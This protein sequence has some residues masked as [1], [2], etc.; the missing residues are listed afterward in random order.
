MVHRFD[1]V[2]LHKW[3]RPASDPPANLGRV[4]ALLAQAKVYEDD[5]TAVFES[6]PA[7]PAEGARRAL[8]RRLAAPGRLARPLFLLGRP[9][10]RL[11]VYNPDPSRPLTIAIEAA[12]FRSPRTV[13]LRSGDVGL[14]RWRAEPGEA[15]T[16]ASPPIR[17]PPASR[18]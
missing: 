10:G 18:P 8:H 2:V 5:R 1:H 9:R 7:R 3:K 13:T 16:H 11:A 15:S 14:A 17:C 4:A 12:A 6:A